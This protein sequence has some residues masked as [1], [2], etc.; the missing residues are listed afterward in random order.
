MDRTLDRILCVR[1]T[2]KHDLLQ[3]NSEAELHHAALGPEIPATW[4]SRRTNY[5]ISTTSD[6]R[7]IWPRTHGIQQSR[8]HF[9]GFVSIMTNPLHTRHHDA[10]EH[11]YVGVFVLADDGWMD[12][13][14]HGESPSLTVRLRMNLS[15]SLSLSLRAYCY[16]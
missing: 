12:G 4:M 16:H 8:T 5:S 10:R 11:H 2:P 15:L 6:I 14:W 7:A 3:R 13:A 1:T 9:L